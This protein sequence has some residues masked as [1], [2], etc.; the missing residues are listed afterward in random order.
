MKRIVSALL[1]L[2]MLLSCASLGCR[3]PGKD[4]QAGLAP[5]ENTSGDPSALPEE[6]EPYTGDPTLWPPIFETD[7][8]VDIPTASPFETFPPA[9]TEPSGSAEPT[10]DAETPRPATQA[11]VTPA[12]SETV[13]AGPT[14]T[15]AQTPAPTPAP[16]P[17]EPTPAPTPGPTPD[18]SAAIT[19]KMNAS[20]PLPN[21]SYDLMY[22]NS[23]CFG[24]TVK[25]DNPILSIRAVISNGSG[26]VATGAVTF[27]ASDGKTSVELFDKTFPKNVSD[28]HSLTAKF[29]FKNLSVGTYTFRL[30]AEAVGV[31]ET[32]LYSSQFKIVKPEW[33]RLIPNDLRN[34]YAYALNFFGSES[35]FM[36]SYKWKAST[37]R[38]III[39]S[40]WDSEHIT[41]V[42]S[43]SGG[44]WY[45]HK[46]AAPYFRQAVGY[47]NSTY[48]RVHGTNGDS[49]VIKL[50]SL[51]KTFDGIL[52]HRFVSDRTFVSHHSF[53][54]AIDL[55]ASMDANVNTLSN[56][57]LIK[58]EVRDKLVY[59]GIK[60]HNG[61]RYYDF[62]YSGSHSNEYR[63]V[64]TTVINYLL[65][66]LAFFRAGFNWG[67]YYDH[68]CDGM[69]FGLTECSADRHNT[70]SRST[71]KVFDYID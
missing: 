18:P 21:T 9:P 35:E 12:P 2:A 34:S 68:C 61:V 38:D 65:Y 13:P 1:L 15:P 52:N 59:N 33:Y 25:C 16:T 30:Y 7:A 69:H 48:V 44:N 56:R 3:R 57:E 40:G 29:N 70:Y 47:L 43:P 36:F 63:E 28:N 53:G 20:L 37:G 23:F 32:Q 8:P 26:T 14:P 42:T 41:S 45:V 24:G 46:K 39:E 60:E 22:G 67:Y 10:A 50:S 64:P 58:T 4:R 66:E 71:R 49:G 51:I 27:S 55:N 5:T 62:T 6:T 17:A 19:L 11:P 31:S 54:A